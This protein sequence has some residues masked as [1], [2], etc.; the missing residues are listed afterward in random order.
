LDENRLIARK[1]AQ[2]YFIYK[3]IQRLA[4]THLWARSRDA[5]G[6]STQALIA[7]LNTGCKHVVHNPSGSLFR[8]EK[9]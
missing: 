5:S 9:D 3:P 7:V 1:V 4:N 8:R 2:R 6:W